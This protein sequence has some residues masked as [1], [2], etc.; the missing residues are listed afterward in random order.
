[1]N[2][3]QTITKEKLRTICVSLTKT[4]GTRNDNS[5]AIQDCLH[6]MVIRQC[7]WRRDF[8]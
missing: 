2:K 5:N 6:V 4:V 3:F 8:T 1:M 7:H